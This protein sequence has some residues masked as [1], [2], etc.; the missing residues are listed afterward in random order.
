MPIYDYKCRNIECSYP[1]L[2]PRYGQSYM[3]ERMCKMSERNDLPTCELC[4]NE[5]PRDYNVGSPSVE[6]K[7]FSANKEWKKSSLGPAQRADRRLQKY[8][9]GQPIWRPIYKDH[10]KDVKKDKKN[11]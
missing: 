4:G 9:N 1:E 8:H 10:Q 7:Y 2:D 6:W 5:M 3:V 11:D